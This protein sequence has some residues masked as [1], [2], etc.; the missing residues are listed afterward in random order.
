MKTPH[1][2]IELLAEIDELMCQAVVRLLQSDEVGPADIECA[3][4]VLA[5]KNYR[6][7]SSEGSQK[8]ER[9]LFN[10][11]DIPHET[12]IEAQQGLAG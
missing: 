12:L 6:G 3:R 4:K 10:V 8:A 7:P 2:Q 9:P 5:S 1:E 11:A